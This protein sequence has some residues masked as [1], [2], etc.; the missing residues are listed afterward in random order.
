MEAFV[1][2]LLNAIQSMPEGGELRV[3]LSRFYN[4][5]MEDSFIKISI[6]DQGSGIHRE[7]LN[8]IF[9]RYYTTKEGG[10]GLGLSIVERIIKAHNGFCEVNSQLK[11]GTIFSIYLPCG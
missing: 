8:K 1:N 10:S 7:S 9:D 11:K 6:T 4:E 2:V 3:A 5:Q